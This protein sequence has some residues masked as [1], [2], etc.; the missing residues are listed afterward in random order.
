MASQHPPV[1]FY[2][3][4]V[5]PK[6]GFTKYSKLRQTPA[7]QNRLPTL[8]F[9]SLQQRRNNTGKIFF[10]QSSGPAP[11][12]LVC[13]HHHEVK[14]YFPGYVMH[15]DCPPL[16]AGQKAPV[17]HKLCIGKLPV[18]SVQHSIAHYVLLLLSLTVCIH[19]IL[20]LYVYFSIACLYFYMH[21]L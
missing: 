13:Y 8:A 9:F 7:T 19:L 20:V 3:D 18:K 6:T 16:L 15:E 21:T 5:H 10:S 12:S 2:A 17:V 14:K 1:T 4:W 11:V